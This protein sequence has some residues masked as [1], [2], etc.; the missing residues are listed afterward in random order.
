M[1][2]LKKELQLPSTGEHKSPII[3]GTEFSKTPV[4][5][6]WAT[7]LSSILTG[8]IL[9]GQVTPPPGKRRKSNWQQ[10]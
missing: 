3:E 2:V 1:N 9:Q 10:I 7:L 5:Y 6:L 4:K 8:E